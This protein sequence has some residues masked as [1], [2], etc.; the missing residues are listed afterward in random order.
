MVLR[1]LMKMAITSCLIAGTVFAADFV[2]AD[3]P[4]I[5]RKP[6]II[7]SIYPPGSS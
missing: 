7:W 4:A 2:R 3:E 1:E 6:A 5:K